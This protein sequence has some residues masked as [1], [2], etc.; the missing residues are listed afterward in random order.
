M[1]R[2][3]GRHFLTLQDF[4]QKEIA[5]ILDRTENL[6]S[7]H[8]RGGAKKLLKGKTLAMLFM[9]PSTRTRVSFETGMYQ[10]GGHAIFLSK[11]HTQI[12]RGESVKD[13]ALVLS[14]YVDG[15]MARVYEHEYL[16]EFAKWSSVP[17]INGLSNFLHPCQALS[18][19]FTIQETVGKLKGVNIAY[20]GESNNV[21]NSLMIGCSKMGIDFTIYSPKQ[22]PINKTIL[23]IARKNAEDSGSE[24]EV[25][26]KIDK[27]LENNKFI[28]TDTWESMHQKFDKKEL[29]KIMI[30]FQIN[31]NMM[32][33]LKKRRKMFYV[34]HDLPAHRGQEIT[35]EVMDSKYSIIFRQA[36][37][38]L[39][40][41]KALMSLIL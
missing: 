18:D 41:Q 13:T 2:L 9:K 28:Y 17:V 29:E 23:K 31:E 40:A 11:D 5:K 25:K 15:V 34:M 22:F 10:L 24:I 35:S 4:S 7:R 26:T 21:S 14:R 16:K 38:R 27:T 8:S 1:N 37:N 33:T 20:V 6:K 12:K 36:E 39:H 19:L 32:K 30:P 3:K